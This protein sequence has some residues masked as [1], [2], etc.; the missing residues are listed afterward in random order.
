MS[1]MAQISVTEIKALIVS[2]H[3]GNYYQHPQYQRACFS[4]I[5]EL[6]IYIYENTFENKKCQTTLIII[7]IFIQIL[8]IFTNF[9]LN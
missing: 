1:L 3:G 9:Y 4:F 8:I 6:Y 5:R 2:V 7:L